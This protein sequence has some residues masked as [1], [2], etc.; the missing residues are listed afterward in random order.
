MINDLKI[1]K[2]NYIYLDSNSY[3]KVLPKVR[4]MVINFIDHP[5]NPSSIHYLGQQANGFVEDTRDCLK[6]YLNCKNDYDVIFTSG[7]SE[8][9]NLAIE[10]ANFGDFD[11]H[12]CSAA[13][14]KSVLYPIQNKRNFLIAS[15]DSCGNIDLEKLIEILKNNQNKKIFL[16]II[17][18]NNETGV[19]NNLSEI[20]KHVRL[21]HDNVVIHSDIA[22]GLG[23]LRDLNDLDFQKLDIDLATVIGYKFGAMVGAGALIYRKTIAMKPMILGGSQEYNLRAGT[24][25]VMAIYS[26]QKKC[27]LHF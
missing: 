6:K 11:L 23:K 9:N 20:V 24:E 10:R 27:S 7:G 26:M 25:N 13:E 4:E 15:V 1:I 21:V 12:I 3:S 14:H 5:L 22:Q 8:A 16:S 17:Y 18:V 19:I 2:D